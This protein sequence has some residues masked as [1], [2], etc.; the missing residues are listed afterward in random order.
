MRGK[1]RVIFIHEFV[2]GGGLAGAAL[3]ATLAAE[4]A[5][6]RRALAADFAAPGGVRVVMTLDDRLD[7]EP[8]PWE[9][10]R[11]G[12]GREL[13]AFGR[14]AAE[15]DDTL[16][17]A[18]ETGGTLRDRAALLDLVGGRSL[19]STPAAIALAGDKF[20]LGRLLDDLGIATPETVRVV[21]AEG[22]PDS[23]PYPAVLKPIDGA[24]ACHTYL[25]T[26]P[27]HLPPGAVELPEAILQPYLPGVPLSASVLVGSDGHVTPI[28]I[29][30]QHIH[31][32]NF[33]FLYEG[34]TVPNHDESFDD[35]LP[36]LAA[37]PGLRGW[38]GVD[39]LREGPGGRAVVLDINPRPTT[40]VVGLLR[41]LPPGSLARAWLAS[42][43]E[44]ESI[45]RI[46]PSRPVTF[47]ADGTIAG[48]PAGP[49]GWLALDIG[50]ANVKA[51]TRGR[52]AWSVPFE[53]WR[54]PGRLASLLHSIGL[55]A[56]P[57]E[58]VA[59]AMTAEL[60]DCFAT[61]A[62]GVRAVLGA[63]VA[64]FPGHRIE[65]WGIDGRFHP[66]STVLHAPA[67]GAASNWLALAI[68]AGRLAP[69]GPG[70]VIDVGSTTTDLIPLRGGRPVP[71][72]RTDTDRLRSG[73]LVYA[74]VRR[75]PFCALATELPWRGAPTPL[76]AELFATT[77]D[78][79]LTLG[80]LGPDP[81][82]RATADG[83]P[84]TAEA[85]RD[86]L[87]RMV[88]ADRDG[89][90]ADD[91]RALALAA[92]E[93]LMARL[94]AMADRA[95]GRFGD[96]PG[97]VVVAGSG[98]FLAR[99]LAERLIEPGGSILSLAEAWGP[100]ASAAA[101]AR[102]LLTLAEQRLGVA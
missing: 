11:V 39:Y 51:A 37:V 96:R 63:V 67:L 61:K 89:F 5:A 78:V 59:V 19:G 36:A 81:E 76:M 49:G 27:G 41:L 57:F 53:T 42:A 4:G 64:A 86:R 69:E 30:T 73:E 44:P 54:R 66:P 21:P 60:C 9:T 15:A 82:D 33:S 98:E 75:T 87:A 43:D 85:A 1:D 80:L 93:A 79:Y 17:I 90:S 8:G 34:G 70:L 91:A 31:I 62:E 56:G 35:L 71:R 12:P 65:V 25:V 26:G 47:R 20:R 102:A 24:G 52:G 94:V 55:E 72:G 74:G 16:L 50:G 23:F 13:E 46:R 32:N 3:P 99:R 22:L 77:L 40:S 45:H 83:R 10:V 48:G 58:G 84:A 88:G 38:V 28:G 92:D 18:P 14:L 29:G 95:R 97:R 6:M 7:A 101:C 68:V 100:T 2:T